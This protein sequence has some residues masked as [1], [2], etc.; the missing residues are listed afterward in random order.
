MNDF[1]L[2]IVIEIG[3]YPPG[4]M[5][6]SSPYGNPSSSLS[7][8][9]SPN[10]IPT[11]SMAYPPSHMQSPMGYPQGSSVGNAMNP[12]GQMSGLPP[13]NQT[14]G[15]CVVIV[16]GLDENQVTPDLLFK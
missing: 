5:G 15:P 10:A 11:H 14:Q 13:M 1:L 9:A 4:V 12:Y 7:G 8:A 6:N 2:I 3:G 16:S